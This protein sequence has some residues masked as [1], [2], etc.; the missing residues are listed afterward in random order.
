[1]NTEQLLKDIKARF[2]HNSSKE[3]LKEKYQSKFIVA[4]QGGLWKAT[5]ELQ[6]YLASRNDETVILS[7]LYD[8]PIMVNRIELY[9]ALRSAYEDNMA[10]WYLEFQELKDKR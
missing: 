2:S 4:N 1:M 7:D 10:A 8:N 3:Y 9:D 6:S 5:P